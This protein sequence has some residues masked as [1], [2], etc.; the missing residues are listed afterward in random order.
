MWTRWMVVAAALVTPSGVAAQ[1]TP[2][3]NMTGAGTVS[4]T[5]SFNFR[6][7]DAISGCPRRICFEVDVA[8]QSLYYGIGVSTA[9]NGMTNME[10]MIVGRVSPTP[11]VWHDSAGGGYN[12]PSSTM[13]V[14]D[15]CITSVRLDGTTVQFARALDGSTCTRSGYTLTPTSAVTYCTA[16]GSWSSTAASSGIVQH[17][18]SPPQSSTTLDSTSVSVASGSG[19]TNEERAAHGTVMIV[20]WICLST[21]SIFTIRYMRGLLGA[22]GAFFKL[23]A[24]VQL[25]VTIMTVVSIIVLTGKTESELD[26][27]KWA[28]NKVHQRLGLSVMTL[29]LVQVIMGAMRNLISGKPSNPSD[30]KDHGP[31]RW[32]FDWLHSTIG[33]ATWILAAAAI[34]RGIELFHTF[35]SDLDESR[36]KTMVVIWAIVVIVIFFAL[37][38]VKFVK[39]VADKFETP[40]TVG[41][42]IASVAVVIISVVATSILADGIK[43]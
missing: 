15:Q 2:Q 42:I 22:G 6:V 40:S 24:A 39:G 41:W 4:G 8:D 34:Y 26:E 23:H 29:A 1:C 32:I 30:P 3:C 14:N 18:G 9:G 20:A 10:K 25:V 33:V 16:R 17:P 5:F 31:N 36:L 13:I 21:I 19:A 38:I 7:Q 43:Q 28:G 12:S 11:Y 37:D 27:S 35:D